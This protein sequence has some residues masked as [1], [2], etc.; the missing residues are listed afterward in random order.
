M[1]FFQYTYKIFLTQAKIQSTRNSKNKFFCPR[2]YCCQF[3]IQPIPAKHH[4]ATPEGPASPISH[5]IPPLQQCSPFSEHPTPSVQKTQHFVCPF[6]QH[7]QLLLQTICSTTFLP[8]H[9]CRD[10]AE[11]CPN[12]ASSYLHV[13]YA[14]LQ[15]SNQ[16]AVLRQPPGT[17]QQAHLLQTDAY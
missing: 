11:L 15:C 6:F 3:K 4:T 12:Y 7:K 13:F 2:F 1:F 9:L 16:A 10:A 5:L 8:I 17:R 14:V